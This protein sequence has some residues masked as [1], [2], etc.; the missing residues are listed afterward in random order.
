MTRSAPLFTTFAGGEWTPLL[1]G[2]AN[3]P[4]YANACRRCRNFIP[5]AT[6]PAVRRPGSRHVAAPK[7][8]ATPGPLRPLL[9]PFE[10]STVQAYIIEATGS[11][12]RFYKDRGRIENPPGTP[13]EIASPYAETELAALKWAQSAD[14]LYLCHPAWQQRKLTRSSHSSWAVSLFDFLDG[15]YLAVNK[16][17]TTLTPSAFTGAG[18]TLTASAV[19]GI[20]GG[21][22]FLTTDVGRLIRMQQGSV[23]GYV[24]ITGWT[25]T[26]VVTVEVKSTLTSIAAKSVWRLGAWSDTTGWPA[27]VTFFQQRLWFANTATEPNTIWG[28]VSGE[29]EN[30]APSE[31]DGTVTDASAVTFTVSD[32]RVNAIRWMV[33]TTVLLVGTIGSEY[34]LSGSST[35]ST[36]TSTNVQIKPQSTVGSADIMPLKVDASALFVQRSRRAILDVGYT[37]ASDSYDPR[38]RSIWGAHLLRPQVAQIAYQQQPWHLVWG[39]CDDGSLIAFTYL[40]ALDV[41]GWHA[42]PLGG[43]DAKVRSIAVIPGTTQD[44]LWVA[45][46]RTVNGSTVHSIEYLT[47][48][49]WPEDA[50]AKDYAIYSD[51]SLAYDGW[52][53]DPTKTLM[54]SGGPP[55]TIGESKTLI[56]A[57]H[58]PFTMADIGRCYRFREAGLVDLAIE[59]EI[60]GYGSATDVTVELLNV[61]PAALQNVAVDWWGACVT[62]VA[63][64]GH[65]EGESVSVLADGA[66]HPAAIVTGGEIA[67]TRDTVVAQVGLGYQSRLETLDIE[68][69]AADGTAF[70]KRQRTHELLVRLFGSLGGRIGYDDDHL[71]E[72][73]YRI[74]S[75]LMGQSPPLF[76]GD[77]LVTFPSDWNRT[78]RVLVIQDQPLPMTVV[79]I[80]PRRTVNE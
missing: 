10:F 59:V 40:P 55:W 76:T 78:G 63:G 64:L 9:I 66:A 80:A 77:K 17:A 35:D 42:H 7:A 79:G 56:A 54:L 38:E 31:T 39:C 12:F 3:H 26:T 22:G 33:P 51:A 6:G 67:L 75:D 23:W 1:H 61:V 24:K 37:Y 19:A 2:L 44:E 4:N 48:E 57:G 70:G 30:F 43:A 21:A 28:S 60:T 32:N 72:L 50:F 16:T 34:S 18:V 71:E 53:G 29:F 36:I 20:N 47:D 8:V 5:N 15:P 49:F 11:W 58:A 45:V 74:G 69:G 13:V 25:S 14:I 68:S 65:L 41:V 27:C 62:T 46:D 52:N 73:P